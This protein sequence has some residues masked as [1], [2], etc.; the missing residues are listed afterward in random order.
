MQK[1]DVSK[2]KRQFVLTLQLSSG[3]LDMKK[4][5]LVSLFI[6]SA[7]VIQGCSS[8]S[9]SG[10]VDHNCPYPS[11]DQLGKDGYLM[12]K[13]GITLKCQVKNFTNRM[14]CAGIT[15]S[16]GSDGWLCDNG[17]RQ[18]LFLFDENGILKDHKFF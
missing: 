8:L 17:K 1:S 11:K 3:K 12:P 13:N 15:D 5:I 10:K 9:S 14:S 16:T 18:A 2:S 4:T 6:M 7:S